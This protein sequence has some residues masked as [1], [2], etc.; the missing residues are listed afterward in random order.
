MSVRSL[1]MLMLVSA[2]SIFL[3][4]RCS[5]TEVVALERSPEIPAASGTLRLTEAKGGNTDVKL[6]VSH[7]AFPERVR[8]GAT[9]YVAWVKP[10]VPNAPP[11]NLG[12]FGVNRELSANLET[13]TP[14]RDFYFFVTAEPSAQ[15]AEPSG[16]PLLQTQ[17]AKRGK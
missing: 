13:I 4:A 7:L 11:Q 12:A 2:A 3:A 14:F 8:P 5:G 9:T 17:V 6:E 10:L 16:A 15:A 1:I